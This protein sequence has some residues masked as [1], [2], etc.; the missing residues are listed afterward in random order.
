MP[1]VMPYTTRQKLGIA[2]RLM[3]KLQATSITCDFDRQRAIV[4]AIC[5]WSYAHRA[6]NG[7]L[8]KVELVEYAWKELAKIGRWKE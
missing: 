1:K 3:H 4:E 2:E 8:D 7:E 6:G 5:S